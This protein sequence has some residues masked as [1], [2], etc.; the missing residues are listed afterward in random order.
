MSA[1]DVS[2]LEEA[3]SKHAES[4]ARLDELNARIKALPDDAATDEVE[5]LRAS[6]EKEQSTSRRWAEAA[7]RTQ[8]IST[9]VRLSPR[10]TKTKNEEDK[11][12]SRS[13]SRWSTSATAVLV[14]PRPAGWLRAKGT[15]TRGPGKARASRHPDAGRAARHLDD[16]GR[17][18]RVRAAGLLAGPV[19][20]AAPS[21]TPTANLMNS[22]PL[23]PGTMVY[24]FPKLSGGA[25]TA[26]QTADNAAVQ[27]TD[28]TSAD[29]SVS[30]KTIAGQVDISRQLY[31]FSN[32]GM[33]E[34]IM[35]DLA[36]DLRRSSTFRCSPAPAR[37]GRRSGSGTSPRSTRSPTRRRPR[38]RQ[39][40]TRRSRT[41]GRRSRRD[42]PQRRRDRHAPA[43][44]GLGAGRIRHDRT[45]AR[46]P[47]T[48][49]STRPS[50]AGSARTTHRARRELQGLPVYLDPNI[51]TNIGAGTNQDIVL[52]LRTAE[53]YL[54][55]EG[56]P[57]TRVFEDVGS[58]TLRPC[59]SRPG[60]T[61]P[62]Q[63]DA[64]QAR[65]R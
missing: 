48:R 32:P 52:V 3:K 18:G 58:G 27:E 17:H 59:G 14:L 30:V 13:R 39:P 41:P 43:A 40:C 56:S 23:I 34:I 53:M 38:P 8:V 31:D 15:P 11:P 35:A 47:P 50:R 10:R 1:Q 6:F 44:L 57:R 28:P 46:N 64:T 42:L 7:E 62:S 36:A 5:F 25:A 9:P 20:P 16:G 2:L 49:P 21:R 45:A 63:A 51:P 33:D 61:S 37:R 24:H 60:A 65:S 4:V 26:I 22:R 19:D 55:E 12:R 29:Y 54:Y